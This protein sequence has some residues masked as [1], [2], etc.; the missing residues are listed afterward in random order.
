MRPRSARSDR[1]A[2]AITPDAMGRLDTWLRTNVAI[3]S[4]LE[5][6]WLNNQR[7]YAK[8]ILRELLLVRIEM[9][10]GPWWN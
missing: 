8:D 2:A 1:L 10:H 4:I 5:R 9:E 7:T 6:K 3:R